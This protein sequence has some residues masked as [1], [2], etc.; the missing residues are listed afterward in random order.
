[1]NDEPFMDA[2]VQVMLFLELSDD[3]T[4]NEDAAVELMEQISATLNGLSARAAERFQQYLKHRAE[5][6]A[7]GIERETIEN[8]ASHLGLNCP[9][10]K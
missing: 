10:P 1:M 3:R 8:L 7:S 5:Q 4:V 9:R 6:C 2:L